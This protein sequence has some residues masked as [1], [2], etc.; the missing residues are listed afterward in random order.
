M[1]FYKCVFEFFNTS[2]SYLRKKLPLHDE[3]LKYAEVVDP[4]KQQQ[5]SLSSIRF[6]I[7]RYRNIIPEGS[8]D[9]DLQ[10][11]FSKF[12]TMDLPEG[13]LKAERMDTAW[14]RLGEM[15]EK[16]KAVLQ[17]L[18]GF[19]LSILTI[20]HSSAHCE[21]IFSIIRKTKTEFRGKMAQDTGSPCCVEVSA[22]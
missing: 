21:R 1:E 2:L 13:V 10:L 18:P 14:V 11:E 9:N 5:G 22:W 7:H 16:G 12:Q 6:F 17:H 4:E 3:L 8:T 15:E 20:P 19:M